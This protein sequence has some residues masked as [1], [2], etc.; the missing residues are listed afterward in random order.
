MPVANEVLINLQE[1]IRAEARKRRVRWTTQRQLIVEQFLF[2][3]DHLT[4][5][6]LHAR[7]RGVDPT[8]GAATVYR[9]LNLLVE[10]GAAQRVRF[11]TGSAAYEPA[12]GRT[13]HDHLICLAC[14]L[15]VE[16]EDERIESRQRLIARTHGFVLRHHRLEMFGLCPACQAKVVGEQTSSG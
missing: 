9:T 8:I 14:G 3:A 6:Q 7:V 13:H 1:R 11:G 12:L 4:A 16:F 10:I 2:A 5:D 15:V